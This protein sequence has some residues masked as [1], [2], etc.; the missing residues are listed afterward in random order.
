[1][2]NYT[3]K[4]TN[5]SAGEEGMENPILIDLLPEGRDRG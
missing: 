2:V 1:M 3:L 4:L 5:E